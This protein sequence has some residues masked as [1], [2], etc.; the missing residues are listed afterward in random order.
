MSVIEEKISNREIQKMIKRGSKS[1][2]LASFFFTPKVRQGT[3][4]LYAWCRYCDDK[5]DGSHLGQIRSGAHLGEDQKT[6]IQFLEFLK[7]NTREAF[8]AQP[9][10]EEPLFVNFHDL[11][12]EF[13]IPEYY[14][15]ELLEGMSMDVYGTHYKTFDDLLLYCYR[16]AGTVGLMMCH[17]M[18]VSNE[19]ALESAAHLGIAMQL[20]NIC[21]D[22]REDLNKGRVYLPT[23]WLENTDN[24]SQLIWSEENE[25]SILRIVHRLLATAEKFYHSGMEGLI[26]LTWRAAF[27][28]STAAFVYSDIGRI[29]QKKGIQALRT[30]TTVSLPRKLFL[31]LK[32]LWVLTKQLPLRCRKP[33]KPILIDTVWRLS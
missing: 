19:H 13:R 20:T 21:R 10:L 22:V 18:G 1:F 11:V 31:M 4:I 7:T 17:I 3:W 32:A 14:P 29:I 24:A 6:Q 5:I 33:W 23:N 15:S 9:V 8:S 30:R 26:H 25:D 2:S 12:H 27:A 28:V 16:V